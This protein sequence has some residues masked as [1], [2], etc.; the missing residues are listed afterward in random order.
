[1]MRLA[2]SLGM[3]DHPD[4]RKVHTKPIPRVGGW[5][6][7][8]GAL[9]SLLVWVRIDEVLVSYFIGST[10]LLLFGSWDDRKEQG[11]YSKF[12]GQ[13]LAVLPVVTYGG[14]YVHM[15]CMYAHTYNHH[16]YIQPTIF[17]YIRTTTI[18]DRTRQSVPIDQQQAW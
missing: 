4:S 8:L 13:F 1:M 7:V 15:A 10:V 3:L 9:I 14:L 17:L 5:G 16:M 12:V 11:H 6:I 2:S 18:A